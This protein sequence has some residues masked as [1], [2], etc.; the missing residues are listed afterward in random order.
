MRRPIVTILAIAILIVGCGAGRAAE[1]RTE[2][3][4]EAT[5][6]LALGDSLAAGWQ[7]IGDPEAD[8]RTRMGYADQLWLIA[9][10]WF[11][12][13]RLVNL[14]CPGATTRTIATVDP[15]CPYPHGSQLD[16][17]LAFVAEHRDAMAFITIDIGF[18]DFPCTDDI[19]CLGPGLESI[20]D[21]LPGVLHALRAAAPH[22][23]IV[24]M[25]IYDPFLSVWLEGDEA[26]AELSVSVVEIVNSHLEEHYR[27]AGVAVADVEAAFAIDD[28]ETLL[29]LAGH[30]MVPRNVALLCLRTWQCH[31]PPLGPDRHPNVL[32]ARVMAEAFADALGFGA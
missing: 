20:R 31:P 28:F 3:P 18:A 26:T 4:D 12:D 17:A 29:P 13:L 32:G 27:K 2:A 30:G 6:Y 23:P 8:H 15:R 25:N 21:G 19:R 7:P 1:A 10:Q 14:A 5:Y 9:R 22:V 24:G 11:P 16:E